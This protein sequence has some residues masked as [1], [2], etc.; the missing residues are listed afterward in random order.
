MNSYTIQC[1]SCGTVL[2]VPHDRTKRNAKTAGEN[3]VDNEKR[4]CVQ[5]WKE[6][7]RRNLVNFK[8]VS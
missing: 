2:H 5:C 4:I 6:I 8:M 3:T 7:G 1:W